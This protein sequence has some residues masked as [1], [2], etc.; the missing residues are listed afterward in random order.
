MS[1]RILVSSLIVVLLFPAISNAQATIKVNDDISFKIGT[2]IQ[3]WGDSAQDA[4]TNGYANNLFLRRIRLIVGGQVAP[5]VTFFFETDNPNLG[6]APKNLG[7]GF[8]R[9]DALVEWK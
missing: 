7:G 8:I 9:Q 6:K 1:H 3:A 2:L 4:A 5:N